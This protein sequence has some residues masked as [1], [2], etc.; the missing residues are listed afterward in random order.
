[1]DRL[2]DIKMA[3]RILTNMFLLA[4]LA[5]LHIAARLCIVPYEGREKMF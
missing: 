2:V 5:L 1:M 4:I 3:K